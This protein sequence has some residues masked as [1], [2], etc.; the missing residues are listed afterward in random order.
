M[1]T[2]QMDKPCKCP[3][4]LSKVFSTFPCWLNCTLESEEREDTGHG[5]TGM[6]LVYGNVLF[7][8]NADEDG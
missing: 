3:L 5:S 4:Q 1:G 6:T 2:K 8:E 7:R